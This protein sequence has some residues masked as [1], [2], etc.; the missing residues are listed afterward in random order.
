MSKQ[1]LSYYNKKSNEVNSFYKIPKELF[2]EKYDKLSLQAKLAYTLMLDRISL[3]KK[4]N[5]IDKDGNVYIIYTRENLAKKLNTTEKTITKI[6]KELENYF[7]LNDGLITRVEQQKNQPFLIYVKELSTPNTKAEK[8]KPKVEN[9]EQ[10]EIIKKVEP[11]E[12][13]KQVEIVEEPKEPE[14]L[15]Q[16]ENSSLS[17]IKRIEVLHELYEKKE[18]T[19]NFLQ[20]KEEL[21]IA[22]EELTAYKIVKQNYEN[23]TITKQKYTSHKLFI[24]SL[25]SMLTSKKSMNLIGEEV[26]SKDIFNKLKENIKFKKDEFNENYCHIDGLEDIVIDKFIKATLNKTIQN[27]KK[28][29]SSC[30]W[31]VLQTGLL[32]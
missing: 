32:Y 6:L 22:L 12:T 21:K 3:S 14:E 19:E 10:V 20:N 27:E 26:S 25:I 23:D 2:E 11:V 4:N 17:I 18:L 29:M 24:N 30:I 31:S 5:W 15:S 16:T 8:T 28:Y 9:I 13:I 1:K 7:G